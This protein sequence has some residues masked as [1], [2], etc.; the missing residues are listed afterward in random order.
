VECEALITVAPSGVVTHVDI[1]KSSG[2]TE[3]DASV[4]A[5][6]REYLFSRGDGRADTVGT[7]KFHFRLERLD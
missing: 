2:Y 5:A 4:E 1:T 6:L 3:I 7:V